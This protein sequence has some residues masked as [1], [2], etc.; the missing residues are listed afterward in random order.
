M[1]GGL[2]GQLAEALYDLRNAELCKQAMCAAQTVG[3][4]R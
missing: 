4:S 1:D 2:R 3:G